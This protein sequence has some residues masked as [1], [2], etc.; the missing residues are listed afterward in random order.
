M[1]SRD[2][3]ISATVDKGRPLSSKETGYRSRPG[4]PRHGRAGLGDHTPGATTSKVLGEGPI[5][6][7]HVLWGAGGP[8][9]HYEGDHE[10]RTPPPML[11]PSGGRCAGR[12]PDHRL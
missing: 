9:R 7:S 12:R 4:M 5:R 10:D 8:D 3:A 2:S 6:P 1:S 11:A